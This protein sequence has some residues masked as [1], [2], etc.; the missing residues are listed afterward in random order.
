MFGEVKYLI[1][2][3]RLN[4][5]KRITQSSLCLAHFLFTEYIG[6]L[7]SAAL[8]RGNREDFKPNEYYV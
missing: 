3:Q 7:T 2:C 5:T 4:I 1:S 6:H 8:E